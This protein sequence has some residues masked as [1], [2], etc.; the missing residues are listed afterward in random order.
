MGVNFCKVKALTEVGAPDFIKAQIPS[1]V[2]DDGL[3]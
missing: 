3:S 1:F 2:A